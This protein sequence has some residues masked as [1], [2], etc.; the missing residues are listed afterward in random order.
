MCARPMPL[1][2]EYPRI[3]IN[4]VLLRVYVTGLLTQPDNGLLVQGLP[5]RRELP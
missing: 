3:G 1:V 4:R 5:K 2:M